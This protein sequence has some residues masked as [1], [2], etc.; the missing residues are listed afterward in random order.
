MPQL[1]AGRGLPRRRLAV[2]KAVRLVLAVAGIGG[3]GRFED[4]AL[5][6]GLLPGDEL[7]IDAEQCVRAESCPVAASGAVAP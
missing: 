6:F 5:G 3:L 2:L 1:L 7:G 4:A